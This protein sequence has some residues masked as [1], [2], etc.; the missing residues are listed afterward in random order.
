MDREEAEKHWEYTE[1]V[2]LLNLK[3]GEKINEKVS[4]MW[5]LDG[6]GFSSRRW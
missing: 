3:I 6:D 5:N 1:K 2:I 4:E